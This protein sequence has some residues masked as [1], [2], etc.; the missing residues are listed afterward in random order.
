MLA[1]RKLALIRMP[2]V[3]ADGGLTVPQKPVPKIL[4]SYESG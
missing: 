3:W 1:E 2:A 4:L